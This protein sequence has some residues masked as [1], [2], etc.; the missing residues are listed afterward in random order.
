M[1]SKN[2]TVKYR[3]RRESKTDY[4]LRR[5]LLAS[6]IPRL[7]I[8]KSLNN[9]NIQI[10]NFDLIGDK[11]LAAAHSKDLIKEGWKY[12]GSDYPAAYLTG[13]LCGAKAKKAGVKKVI[14][15][16]GLYRV[17]K[18]SKL[19]AAVKGV[20]D[21]GIDVVCSKEV[22]PSEETCSGKAIAYYAKLLFVE[23]AEK[24][25]KQF[26]NYLKKSIKPED[27]Q[28]VFSKVKEDILNK[29]W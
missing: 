12:S 6:G 13:L 11:V 20:L 28:K 16:F 19:F 21:A 27:I 18:R 14:V 26:S 7:V 9:F 8:R 22:L 10:Y 3:R 29:K 25:K 17:V 4:K 1:T 15:D 23:N 24:Y 5:T 2:F